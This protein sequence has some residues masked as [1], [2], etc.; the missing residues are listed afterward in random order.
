MK[1]F[2]SDEIV[3]SEE[4]TVNADGNAVYNVIVTKNSNI[5]GLSL[6]VNYDK[7]KL[8]L[9]DAFAGENF[10]SSMCSVNK[11]IAGTVYMSSVT[12]VPITDGGSVITLVFDGNNSAKIAF[13]VS[14]CID[15]DMNNLSFRIKNTETDTPQIKDNTQPS[16]QGR[17]SSMPVA[18]RNSSE[19]KAE[20]TTDNTKNGTDNSQIRVQDGSQPNSTGTTPERTTAESEKNG[21]DPSE[22]NTVVGS[23][24]YSGNQT[25]DSATTDESNQPS[26]YIIWIIIS[27]VLCIVVITILI[28]YKKRRMTHEK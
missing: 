3:F 21:I 11:K 2:A 26:S 9:L 4:L 16:T 20:K 13:S 17:D 23:M 24:A 6:T 18:T 8:K 22:Q 28:F 19:Q 10:S 7:D 25:T 1:A 5:A 15:K 27:I 14:E 12:T